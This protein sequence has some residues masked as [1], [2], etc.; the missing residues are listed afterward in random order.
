VEAAVKKD[1]FLFLSKVAA[2]RKKS[3]PICAAAIFA[4]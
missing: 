1:E 4:A 2:R 3:S